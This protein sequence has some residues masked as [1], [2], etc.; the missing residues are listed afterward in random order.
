MTQLLK[1]IIVGHGDEELDSINGA[2]D[3][4]E[5]R[6]AGMICFV[7]L[8]VHVFRL[9]ICLKLCVNGLDNLI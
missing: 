9:E 3:I 1:T 4:G 2:D 8:C 5:F 7:G 6:L